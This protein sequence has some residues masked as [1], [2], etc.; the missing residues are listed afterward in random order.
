MKKIPAPLRRAVIAFKK[1]KRLAVAEPDK[2]Y[3]LLE[4]GPQ[5]SRTLR[6]STDRER[7]EYYCRPPQFGVTQ[8]F[9]K[10]RRP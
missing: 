4:I 9:L 1:K 10:E 2:P 3:G 7:F 6:F 5:G 8:V